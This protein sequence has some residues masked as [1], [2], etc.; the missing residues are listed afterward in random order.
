[1][2]PSF[3]VL[4]VL[5]VVALYLQD[6]LSLLHYDEL[7]L[8][9]AGRRWRASTGGS[10]W[11]GRYLHVSNPL[12]P[13]RALFRASWLACPPDGDTASTSL[14]HFLDALQPFRIVARLMW[15]ELLVALPLLLWV[16]PHPLAV[17]ALFAVIYASAACLALQ[18]WRYRRVLELANRDL[19]LLAFEVLACPPYAINVVRRLGLRRG[20]PDDTLAFAARILDAR[21]LSRLRAAIES[22]ISLA[23]DLGAV[24]DPRQRS[25]QSA[26]S[27]LEVLAP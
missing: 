13:G 14:P 27:R 26:R 21:E 25:L 24:S 15:L 16:F 6:L 17:L 12:A 4:L 5:G 3:E 23:S 9:H 18:L 22:R 1:M 11:A 19:A 2:A 20:L 10:Q 7:V 8:V